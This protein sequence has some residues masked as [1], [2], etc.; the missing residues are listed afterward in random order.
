ML[1]LDSDGKFYAADFG[2]DTLRLMAASKLGD[3]SFVGFPQ[4]Y[5]Y[6]ALKELTPFNPRYGN[7]NPPA[8]HLSSGNTIR[9]W[10]NRA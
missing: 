6:G 1:K 7:V 3:M 5:G 4:R 2:L 10:R 8:S 9:E